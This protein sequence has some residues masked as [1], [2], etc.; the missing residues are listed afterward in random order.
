MIKDF[1]LWEDRLTTKVWPGLYFSVKRKNLDIFQQAFNKR[2]C[3]KGI[4]WNVIYDEL[5]NKK[6]DVYRLELKCPFSDV[7]FLSMLDE[8]SEK[9]TEKEK[10]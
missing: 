10:A 8:V 3:L 1:F 5:K 6:Y 7:L 4:N 9:I 2:F